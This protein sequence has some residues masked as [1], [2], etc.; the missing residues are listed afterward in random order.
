MAHK[1][2]Q[3]SFN[4]DSLH[5]WCQLFKGSLHLL[6]EWFGAEELKDLL[7]V[8]ATRVSN[9]GEEFTI[10]ELQFMAFYCSNYS[11]SPPTSFT[12]SPVNHIVCVLHWQVISSILKG[13]TTERQETFKHH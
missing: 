11:D 13:L 7:Q 5:E 2:Q 3:R 4:D 12:V 6:R 10:P 1:G 9:P 8:V